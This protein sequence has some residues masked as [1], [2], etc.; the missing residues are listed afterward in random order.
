MRQNPKSGKPY[1]YPRPPRGGRLPSR[2]HL[3]KPFCDFYPRPPRGGR[4]GDFALVYAPGQ[5]LSTPSARRAT[6]AERV[7]GY[8]RA[9]SIHA[10]REEGDPLMSTY[11]PSSFNF[12]PRPPRGG[13]LHRCCRG[14]H[15]C[16]ISI[17]ALREEGDQRNRGRSQRCGIS[18]H[19]LREEGDHR[20]HFSWRADQDFYPRPPRGGRRLRP[21]RGNMGHHFYPRPPRGGR[22]PDSDEIWQ[23]LDISIHA[24]RE[25]GDAQDRHWI[26]LLRHFYPRPPRGGR[27]VGRCLV[28]RTTEFLS[29]PSARRATRMAGRMRAMIKNF[30]PRPPRGGRLLEFC[31]RLRCFGISIHALREEGDPAACQRWH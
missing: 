11:R 8:V 10:L 30:Y 13:R 6:G 28:V 22:R 14:R 4:R 26:T 23:Q 12:Y 5:F 31:Q 2:C 29:T 25:E 15:F 7:L 1:F 9:I 20:Q 16:G 18:I 19:A 24:L 3:Q 27:L 17:H 21:L